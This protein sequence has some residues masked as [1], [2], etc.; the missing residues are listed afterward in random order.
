MRVNI[1]LK[2]TIHNFEKINLVSRDNGCSDQYVCKDCGLKGERKV[3]VGDMIS[4][5]GPKDKIE[6]CNG[7]KL[8]KSNSLV[9]RKVRV[10]NFTGFGSAFGNIVNGSIHEIVETPSNP[11]TKPG[12]WVMGI[13][14]PVKLLDFEYEFVD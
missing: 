6:K 4:V 1:S 11:G 3:L 13:G 10:T 7:K 2:N 8:G 9:G 12:V 14:E 5:S